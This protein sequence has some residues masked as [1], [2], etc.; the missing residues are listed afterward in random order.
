[1]P[2]RGD[3]DVS[4]AEVPMHKAVFMTVNPGYG[5][6]AFI[7]SML[8]KIRAARALADERGLSLDIAVD[9]G[10]NLE[11]CKLVVEAGANALIAG[12]FVFTNPSGIDAA[13]S[14]LRE[15]RGTL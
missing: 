14:G 4:G 6:Q 1:M 9:G 8:P 5:G 11:T 2:F 10:V 12:S 3:Q 13:I 15:R 7:H